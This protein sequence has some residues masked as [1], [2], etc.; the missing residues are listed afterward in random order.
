MYC[1]TAA[2]IAIRCAICIFVPRE[3]ISSN[4]ASRKFG[5]P[6]IDP[7][8]YGVHKYHRESPAWGKM[9]RK[10]SRLFSISRTSM[11]GRKIARPAYNKFPLNVAHSVF[12]NSQNAQKT[13]A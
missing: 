3:I 6:L 2:A 8:L 5:I 10:K 12:E 7:N 1:L 4:P 13:P 11:N 9:P